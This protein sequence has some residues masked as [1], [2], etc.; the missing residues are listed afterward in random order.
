[1]PVRPQHHVDQHEQADGKRVEGETPHAAHIG[2][3]ALLL[4]RCQRSTRTVQTAPMNA[5]AEPSSSTHRPDD[6]LAVAKMPLLR[7][8]L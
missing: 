5:S 2:R 1:V 7:L 3:A 6:T 4:E 8:T